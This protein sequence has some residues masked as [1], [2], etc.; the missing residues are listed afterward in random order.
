MGGR[1]RKNGIAVIAV[2]LIALILAGCGGTKPAAPAPAPSASPAPAP[3]AGSGKTEIS[4]GF[5]LPLTGGSSTAGNDVVNAYRMWAEQVNTAGGIQVKDQGKKLKVKLTEY[6]DKSDSKTAIEMYERLINQDKVDLLLSDWGSGFNNAITPITDKAGYPLL[7]TSASANNIYN[8]G[9]KTIFSTG[10][11]ASMTAQPIADYLIANKA[12]LKTVAIAYENFLY[13][14]TMHEYLIKFLADAGIKPVV[15]EQYPIGNKDFSSIL[16][17]VKAAN[18]DAFVLL[19]IMPA[20]VYA[21]RQSYEVGLKP[22]FFLSTIGPQY[23]KEFIEALGGQSEGVFEPGLWHTDMPFTGAKAFA[24]AFTAKY[25]KYPSIDAVYAYTGCQ[26]LQQAVEQA[27]TL[28]RA[29]I[30]AALHIGTFDTIWGKYKYGEDGINPNIIPFLVQ[31]QKGKRV[32]VYPDKYANGTKPEIGTF[33][34]S[35]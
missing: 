4:I 31:V 3:A 20:S 21:V 8:R 25:G 34:V 18:P 23:T 10:S 16:T 33:G 14:T 11:V 2:G 9:F 24:D 19:N 29:K 35:K 26:V 32:I 30:V 17:K 7:L 12:T 6:D 28:D 22:K 15:D 1:L 5:A 27:G 13:T